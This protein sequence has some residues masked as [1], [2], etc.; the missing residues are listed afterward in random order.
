MSVGK[1]KREKQEAIWIEAS[2]L[3]TPD[4][5]PFYER[6]N[7]L[8]DKRKFDGFGNAGLHG[9]RPIH[10]RCVRFWATD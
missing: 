3:A 2:S 8:L 1:R 4:G 10:W 5:H 6:L 9:V 7:I